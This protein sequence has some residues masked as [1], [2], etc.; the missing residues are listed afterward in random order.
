MCVQ[1]VYEEEWPCL[2][3][4]KF[5]GEGRKEMLSYFRSGVVQSVNSWEDTGET[6][7]VFNLDFLSFDTFIL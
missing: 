7:L 3:M 6:H 1:R 2:F 5:I 4:L